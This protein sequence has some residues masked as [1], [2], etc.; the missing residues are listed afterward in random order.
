MFAFVTISKIFV[1]DLI[2]ETPVIPNV[3]GLNELVYEPAEDSFL[4]LDALEQDL[5]K[6]FE[7]SGSDDVL[8]ILEV[9]CGSGIVSTALAKSEKLL[10]GRLPCVFALDVNPNACLLTNKTGEANQVATSSL[11]TIL[12]D[13]R[14]CSRNPF[15]FQFDLV[16]CN[17]PYVPIL[18]G[19]NTEDENSGLL[20]QSWDGGPDGN[21][22]IIPFL[23]NVRHL[24]NN[25]GSL[26]LLLSSWNNPEMLV[27]DVAN[28]NGL[29]G[30][31]VIKRTAGRERLS[32]WKFQKKG[33]SSE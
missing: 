4:L 21:T 31:Q 18:A 24:L 22:F 6:S 29:T 30:V 23:S 25:N 1:M 11:H 13:G 9:G 16:I 12:L 5:V 17:P 33:L 7:E 2:M 3:T 26:Y 28:P 10:N 8:N 19:E 32:V 20:Q 14:F 15:R 27:Q